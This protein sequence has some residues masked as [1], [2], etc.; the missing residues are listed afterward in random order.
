MINKKII[1]SNFRLYT[2]R[3][4]SFLSGMI[5]PIIGIFIAWG[6]L[7]AF[8]V[9]TGWTPNA[10]LATMISIGITYL[11]PILVAFL[12]GRK[13]YGMRGAVIGALVS[14]SA[15]AA[16][17]TET[18]KEITQSTGTM[19]LGAMIYGP[20]AAYIL[21]HTEKYW[22]NKIKPGFEMLVNNFYLGILGFALAC[23][24]FYIATYAIG[25]LIVGL[26]SIVRG[27]ANYSLYPLAAIIVEPAK[28]LFLN[29]AINHGVFTPLGVQQVSETGKSILFLLES[30]PGP[31]LGILIL[32][33]FFGKQ[34]SVKSEAGSASVIHFFGGIHEVYFPFVLLKPT[35]ILALIPAGAFANAM[36]QLF[37][38]GATGIIS[39]GS[40]IAQYLQVNKTATDLVGLSIGIFGSAIVSFGVGL[41][42]FWF[43]K[44]V[45][46][47]KK[48]PEKKEIL[49]ISEAKD[50]IKEI[51]SIGKTSDI[52]KNEI[53][54][55]TFVCDAGM[56]SS[57]MGSA[58]LKKILKEQNLSDIQVV[59]KSISD[60]DG[61][62][63]AIITIETLKDRVET[64]NP[65]AQKFVLK[66]FLNKKGYLNVIETIKQQEV[67]NDTRNNKKN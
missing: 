50:K 32:W 56:G 49:N 57:V 33:M 43:E 66:E 14:I 51:K 62:E 65:K 48:I 55:I 24:G 25:Y 53:K 28:V 5:M 41:M 31:G 18:F 1:L 22:I 54:I 15:I 61:T 63:E 27:L 23:A 36:F 29:N 6:L 40:I 64:K 35:L 11:I 13:I 3:F 67:P 19:L 60:L 30:N 45:R 16:G 20:L 8:F 39:P 58:I 38:V 12:G 46:K 17:Q 21:K 52:I 10:D 47:I 9:E 2:Q 37:D 4:G 26:G 34:K 59:H 44:I 7:T 42:I